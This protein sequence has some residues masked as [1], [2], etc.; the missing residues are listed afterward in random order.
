MPLRNTNSMPCY[1]WNSQL[2]TRVERKSF[3]M[4]KTCFLMQLKAGCAVEH[5]TKPSTSPLS[6]AL[7]RKVSPH[8]SECAFWNLRKLCLWNPESWALESRIQ[9]KESGIPPMIGIQ[10][11]NFTDKDWNPVPGI[12]NPRLRIQNQRLSCQ[13][14]HLNL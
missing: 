12:R 3:R 13:V 11:P 7:L 6:L 14:E 9:L 5:V 2:R 1:L 10:N 8:V 4:C